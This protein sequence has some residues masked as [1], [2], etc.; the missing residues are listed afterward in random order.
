[1]SYLIKEMNEEERPRERFKNYGVEALSNEELLSILMRTGTKA[2]SVKQISFELLKKYDIHDFQK[3]NY[4]SIKS[5]SGIG[6]AKALSILAA[7]EFGKRVFSRKNDI[8]Q[9][10]TGDDV[11]LLCKDDL[12]YEIQE[13]FL[14]IYLDSR[15]NV[16]DKKIIF[17]G[18]VNGSNV[19]PRDVFREGVRLNATSIIIVHNHP[20]GHLKASN[21][22]LNLT[23][24]FIRLGKMIGI[25]ITDHIIIAGDKFLSIRAENPQLFIDI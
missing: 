6:D 25:T 10:K 9:I 20:A 13:K 3:I 19:T 22:D 18:T 14:A 17:V 2:K 8:F 15:K 5:I 23:I 21:E 12:S 1:M 16:I 24:D 11:F 4:Q 7:I